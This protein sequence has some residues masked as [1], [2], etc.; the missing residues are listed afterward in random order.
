MTI[1][2]KL[3]GALIVAGPLALGA[4]P[5]SAA[6]RSIEMAAFHVDVMHD[7]NRRP[8]LRVEHRPP[9]PHG[10]YH[11]RDGSWKWNHDHWQWTSGLWIRF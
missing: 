9:M 4:T 2:S 11:W 5:A 3:A 6:P 8:P 1:K 10:R 7:H